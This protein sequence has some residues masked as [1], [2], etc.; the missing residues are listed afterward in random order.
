VVD[1]KTDAGRRIVPLTPVLREALT[2][3]RASSS[4][5]GFV[6]PSEAGTARDRHNVRHRIVEPTIRPLGTNRELVPNGASQAE[7][8]VGELSA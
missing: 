2:E 8:T 3:H 7:S 1:S 4:G 5:E 6:F